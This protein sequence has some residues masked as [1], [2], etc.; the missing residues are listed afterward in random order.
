MGNQKSYLKACFRRSKAKHTL[1][2]FLVLLKVIPFTFLKDEIDSIAQRRSD[3]EN[4]QSRR[5][6]TELMKHFDGRKQQLPLIFVFN[7]AFQ[8][9]TVKLPAM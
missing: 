3:S 6:K 5:I 9:L 8:N 1:F 7:D 4:E 2:Y